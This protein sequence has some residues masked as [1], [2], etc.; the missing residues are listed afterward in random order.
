MRNT[1]QDVD[2]FADLGMPDDNAS[3]P[4]P[5]PSKKRRQKKDSTIE[6]TNEA[7]KTPTKQ[8][9]VKKVSTEEEAED[10]KD[11]LENQDEA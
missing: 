8:S 11:E 4:T 3:T 10:N 6:S 9:R 1:F 5:T 2:L 7:P